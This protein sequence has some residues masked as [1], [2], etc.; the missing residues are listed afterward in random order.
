[1]T[2][3]EEIVRMLWRWAML[4]EL[5]A[6][7]WKTVIERAEYENAKAERQELLAEITKRLQALHVPTVDELRSEWA[8]AEARGRAL[9]TGPAPITDES[10]EEE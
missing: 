10:G 7:G 1:M 4:V 9:V 8:A 5:V 6:R 2:G 3:I